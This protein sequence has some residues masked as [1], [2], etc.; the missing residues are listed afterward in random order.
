[1]ETWNGWEFGRVVLLISAVMYAG[2]WMQLTLFH[3]NAR[4]R[5]GPMLWPAL[6][7]PLAIVF[8]LIAVVSRSGWPG[9]AA[10]VLLAMSIMLGM[11]GLFFHV[12]GVHKRFGGFSVR[13]MSQGPPPI[14]PLA[15]S[16]NGL[17]GLL[18]LIWGAGLLG[19]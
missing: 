17:T 12:R 6:F 16:I 3:W 14:L 7:T 2:M 5:M 4:F 8:A 9:W 15:Y 1:M 18:A 13:N 19:E 10:L 11:A